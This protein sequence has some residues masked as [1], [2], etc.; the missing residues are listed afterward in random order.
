MAFRKI[1]ILFLLTF[2][3]LAV[4]PGC[5]PKVVHF[6]N[7]RSDFGSYSSYD[8]VNFKA[9]NTEL[10]AEGEQIF[11]NI[12]KN[13]G[14]EL[15][16]RGYTKQHSN[17]NLIARYE[18]IS[19]QRTEVNRNVNPYSF[20]TYGNY[21]TSRTFLESALLIEIYDT[22]TRKLVWQAS[23]DLNKY[24]KRNNKEE[25]LKDAVTQLFNTYLYRANSKTPDE[26]L[27][28]EQ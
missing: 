7:S 25:I 27:I 20:P 16:L 15:K 28:V 21:S 4:L 1:H 6:V 9:S 26:S 24:A 5:N 19:N 13:I 2:T 22:T 12:E 10:S 23:V 14:E 17:P 3:I 11:R 8:V 18:L